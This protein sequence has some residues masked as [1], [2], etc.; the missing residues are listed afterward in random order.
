MVVGG[1]HEVR[2]D[3]AVGGGPADRERAREQPEGA[4][5]RGF[6]ERP[7]RPDRSAADGRRL[8]DELGGAVR[9]QAHVRGVVAQQEPDEGDDGDRRARH[10][11]GGRPPSVVLRDPGQQ[12]QEDQLPCGACR[13]EDAGDQAAAGDEPPV[14]DG[15]GEGEGHGP[16]AEADQ[17]APAQDELPHLRHGD[18]QRR[19]ERD[20]QQ[21]A[22]DDPPDAEAVHQ[23]G[24]EGGGD[25]VQRE[26]D[27]HGQADHAARPAEFGV[28]RVDQQT[29]EGGECSSTDQR[30]EGDGGDRPGAVR[31][32]SAAGSGGDA[33]GGGRGSLRCL[34]HVISL[35]RPE[36][37]DEWPDGHDMQESSHGRPAAFAAAPAVRVRTPAACRPAVR[38]GLHRDHDRGR[39]RDHDRGRHRG[40][41]RGFGRGLRRGLPSP[42]A[43]PCRGVRDGRGDPVRTGHPAA[44]LRVRRERRERCA[45]VRD[46]D[47]QRRAGGGADRR[48]LPDRGAVRGGGAGPGR[49]RR[50]ARVPRVGGGLHRGRAHRTAQ[51]RLR[52]DPAGHAGG[53]D[54]HRL[55]PAG[56]R[57]PAG[58]PARDDALDQRRPLPA[59]LP[60][61]QG[62]PRRALRGR[63]G[64]AD[65]CGGG[66]RDRPVPAHR[67]PGLRYRGRELGVPPHRGAAAPRGRAGAVH[68]PAAAGAAAGQHG[69]GQELGARPA[70]PAAH[71]AGVG[72]AGVDERTHLHPALP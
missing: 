32:R 50:R 47:V 56:R 12:R 68:P 59:T 7:Q 65:L 46:R 28:Q 72:R 10:D 1:G 66:L 33:A 20:R 63:R 16:A 35:G 6:T 25:P 15:G 53:V 41:H 30:H 54:L 44:D 71:A 2:L 26:V 45:A 64:R 42:G 22:D 21:G 5:T 58:R 3:E 37:R 55:V 51:G 14:G 49:H 17:D 48:R 40:R 69:A 70:G 36:R 8:G 67:A 52:G 39:H 9:G 61:G 18:G 4:S 60:A 23:R 11:R 43:A 13:G 34:R 24:G 38:G 19:A 57:G 62:R 27:R 29:R 31:A